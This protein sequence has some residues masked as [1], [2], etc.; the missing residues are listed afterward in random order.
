MHVYTCKEKCCKRMNY[1]NTALTIISFAIGDQRW[2]EMGTFTVH[3]T[4]L[5]IVG[6]FC[7]EQGIWSM[8]YPGSFLTAHYYSFTLW[9][10]FGYSFANIY[11]KDAL[12]L[13]MAKSASVY[14][15]CLQTVPK[16]HLH[17]PKAFL[18]NLTYLPF[19]F[20]RIYLG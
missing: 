8:F 4:P 9:L 16:H 7:R 10:S 2:M 11:Y 12:L 15:L 1:Y 6:F 3:V 17:S 13:P 5:T 18:L 19:Q 20:G 14:I